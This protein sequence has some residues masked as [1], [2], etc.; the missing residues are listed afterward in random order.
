MID[1]MGGGYPIT[2]LVDGVR[3]MIQM[4]LPEVCIECVNMR[5]SITKDSPVDAMEIGI[6]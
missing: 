5:E 2:K 4:R 6:D 1:S 3:E